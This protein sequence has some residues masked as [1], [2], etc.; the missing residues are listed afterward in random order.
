MDDYPEVERTKSAEDVPNNLLQLV[1]LLNLE[2]LYV[3]KLEAPYTDDQ[4]MGHP[5]QYT[6]ASSHCSLY[7][8]RYW[9]MW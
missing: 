6:S 8:P 5:L 4:L 9:R 2:R 1:G 3:Q 7:Q